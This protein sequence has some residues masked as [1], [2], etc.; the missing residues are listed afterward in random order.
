LTVTN[1]AR[2]S[3]TERRIYR[4]GK[5]KRHQEKCF[6]AD[7]SEYAGGNGGRR[8]GNK[9]TNKFCFET[10]LDVTVYDDFT[11][12]KEAPM[13]RRYGKR[14][15]DKNDACTGSSYHYCY[16]VTNERKGTKH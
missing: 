4:D 6:T 7:T 5:P 10:T 14:D 2:Q 15:N 9:G 11:F 12:K 1:H 16:Y 3:C 8:R 13:R